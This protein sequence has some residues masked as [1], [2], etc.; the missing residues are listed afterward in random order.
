MQKKEAGEI[1]TL[2]WFRAYRSNFCLFPCWLC[3]RLALDCRFQGWSSILV[4]LS[5]DTFPPRRVSSLLSRISTG[6]SCISS[7]LFT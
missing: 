4:S 7:R 5:A 3:I 1:S 6:F 2:Q